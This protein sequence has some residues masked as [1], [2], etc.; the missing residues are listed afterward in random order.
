M[1]YT[2]YMATKRLAA[3]EHKDDQLVHPQ[4]DRDQHGRFRPGHKGGPGR[5]KGATI[6]S[7]LRRQAD[8][9]RIAKILLSMTEDPKVGNRERLGALQMIT[10]RLDGKAISR[11]LSLT[12][13]A[14][15]RLLPPGF[16]ALSPDQ[17]LAALADLRERALSGA[18]LLDDGGQ[19]GEND[20][21]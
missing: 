1:S 19:H 17:R 6:T 3:E 9:E 14:G 12:L 10:D 4:D 2:S 16:L 7:E 13:G 8:P 5:R 20:E 11:S 15:A 18:L 21:D